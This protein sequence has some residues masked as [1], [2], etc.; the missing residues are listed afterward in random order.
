MIRLTPLIH[1]A[2]IA[3]AVA[4]LPVPAAAQSCGESTVAQAGDS[5][6]SIARRCGVN[7]KDLFVLNPGVNPAEVG[8]GR[9]IFV[10]RPGTA[11]APGLAEAYA[12]SA[13]GHWGPTAGECSDGRWVFAA[14]AIE[15]ENRSFDI[16]G[17]DGAPGDLRVLVQDRQSGERVVLRLQPSGERMTVTG[18]GLL[19]SLQRC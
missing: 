18:G 8:A 3:A 11:R 6:L 5:F 2:A 17:F 13:V 15:G 4:V 16:L 10:A 9:R 1:A 14:R 7:M 12:A 19:G